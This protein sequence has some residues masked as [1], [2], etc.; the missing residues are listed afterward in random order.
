ML[1]AKGRGVRRALTD[2]V[3]ARIER[4]AEFFGGTPAARRRRAI[5]TLAC[6][7]GA[8]TLARGVDDPALSKEISGRGARGVRQAVTPA[9]E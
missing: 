7:V 8:L 3:A 4:V 9:R 2:Y 6:M 1:R 5:A